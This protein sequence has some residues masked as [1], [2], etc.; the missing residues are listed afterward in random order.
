MP[1]VIELDNVYKTY[2][3]GEVK[4]PALR[5]VSF[6]I[7]AGEFVAIVGASGSGKSTLMNVLG[8]LDR[9]TSGSYRFEGRDV[10]QLD[11]IALARLRNDKLGFVFQG[12][13][14][15]KRQTAVENVELPLLYAGVSAGERRRRALEMLNLKTA[16]LALAFAAAV[17]LGGCASDGKQQY[18]ATLN[19]T[20]EVPP[21]DSKG[22]GSALLTFDPATKVLTY[23]ITY[24][25]LKAAPTAA[26][27][28]GPAAVGANAG[29]MV[30]FANPASPIT[31]SATLTDAQ[32]AALTA[33]QTYV[34]IHSSAHPPG[35]IRGQITQ[36]M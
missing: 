33:G 1:S 12:F 21:N 36:G 27:I 4:I 34:N 9:P 10:S 23:N 8:C 16:G 3:T 11:R 13:N 20:S 31:G 2:D 14:L 6:T 28:H 17:V 22:I 18:K 25:G 19:G 35:E 26:H 24:S 15:L 5:G 30:P 7:D 32:A 29:V